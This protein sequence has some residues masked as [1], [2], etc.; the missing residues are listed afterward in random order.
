MAKA[1]R[2]PIVEKET[3]FLSLTEKEAVVLQTILYKVGGDPYE[4]PRK[5]SQAISE[6]LYDLSIRS[7]PFL[8]NGE[9]TLFNGEV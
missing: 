3:V 1:T 6:A 8:G 7:K 5:H 9:I 4:S 2:E